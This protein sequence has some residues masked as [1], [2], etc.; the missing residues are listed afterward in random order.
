MIPRSY[1]TPSST[2]YSISRRHMLPHYSTGTHLISIGCGNNH[3]IAAAEQHLWSSFC[4]FQILIFPAL[5]SA[6]YCL[7]NFATKLTR[8]LPKTAVLSRVFVYVSCIVDV[9]RRRGHTNISEQKGWCTRLVATARGVYILIAL[10]RSL[11]FP[12]YAQQGLP[13]VR[14]RS[15][16]LAYVASA[17]RTRVALCLT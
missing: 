6:T 2:V 11:R 17:R 13:A 14:A 12:A 1:T 16:M 5:P 8:D 4:E 10:S 3:A 7:D 15:Q 9:P